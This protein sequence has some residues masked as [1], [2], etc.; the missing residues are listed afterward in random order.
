[1][2]GGV[3]KAK[4]HSAPRSGQRPAR[5]SRAGHRDQGEK[6]LGSVLL[7]GHR[8][9][10]AVPG[11]GARAAGPPGCSVHSVATQICLFHAEHFRDL[12][13]ATASFSLLACLLGHPCGLG[14]RVRF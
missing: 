1:M 5:G 9:L 10:S 7:L 8:L 4:A 11:Q 3:L 13:P 2:G 14:D 6:T 12:F